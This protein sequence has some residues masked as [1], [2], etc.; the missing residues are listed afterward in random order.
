MYGSTLLFKFSTERL[1]ISPEAGFQI[2][3]DEP[4]YDFE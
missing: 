2:I 4:V 3:K 1:Y